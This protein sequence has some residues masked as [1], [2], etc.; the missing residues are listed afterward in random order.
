M[1]KFEKALDK[2][3]YNETVMLAIP[4]T[5]MA[6]GIATIIAAVVVACIYF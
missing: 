3:F 2:L 5:I 6:V 4:V 1:K